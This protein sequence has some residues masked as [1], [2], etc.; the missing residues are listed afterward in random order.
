M[1]KPI[2]KLVGENGNVFN[3]IGIASVALKN[4]GLRD[5]AKEMSKKCFEAGSY[6]EVLQIVMDYVDVE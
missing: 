6:D 3:L 2:T 5:Q 1:E 4:A